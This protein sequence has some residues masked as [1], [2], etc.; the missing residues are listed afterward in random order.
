MGHHYV[1]KYY[2]KGFSENSGD[3]IWVYGKRHRLKFKASLERVASQKRFYSQEVEQY[4]ANKIEG[5]ANKVLAKI[6][7]HSQ[8]TD[9]DKSVLA[10]YILVMFKRVPRGKE[11][12]KEHMLEA[13]NKVSQQCKEV[14]DAVAAS[15][16]EMAE[17]I[18]D[19][20][21]RV[22]KNLDDFVGDPDE[23]FQE[24]LLG[25][26]TD[27]VIPWMMSMT[28][29]FLSSDDKPAFLTCDNPFY[30]TPIGI[31]K[32]ESE[33]SFPISSHITLSATRRTGLREGYIRASERVV[34]QMNRRIAANATRFVYHSRDEDWIL[35][36]ITKPKWRRTPVP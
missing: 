30:F 23:V 18:E 5:P 31:L 6:R 17:S 33:I 27:I 35:P 4:L 20:K 16:P 9:D 8:I 24:T 2:L 19:D 7:Q 11:R 34:K 1:P 10:K 22:R 15:S 13:A 25:T 14:L 12:V 32:P 26:R 29:H 3:Y 28:W 21:E 36:F